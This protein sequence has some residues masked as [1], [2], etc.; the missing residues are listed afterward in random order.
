MNKIILLLISLY[1][2]SAIARTDYVCVNDCAQKGYM[3][4]SC[5]QHCSI[6]DQPR[7]ADFTSAFE[8][9]N[10]GIRDNNIVDA[11]HKGEMQALELQRQRLEIQRLQQGLNQ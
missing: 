7:Q 4:Q 1:A 10:Q 5:I 2:M 8:S 9:M 6:D 3:Y 11:I